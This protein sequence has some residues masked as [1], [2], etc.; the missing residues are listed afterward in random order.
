MLE[1][2]WMKK[3]IFHQKNLTAGAK[4]KGKKRKP[5]FE[6]SLLQETF[7]NILHPCLSWL[8]CYYHS[9]TVLC[10]VTLKLNKTKASSVDELHLLTPVWFL[11]KKKMQRQNFSGFTF[12]H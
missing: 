7:G 2:K 10:F 4:R 3:F 8:K 5:L 9:F 1:N 11:A 12:F 6:S